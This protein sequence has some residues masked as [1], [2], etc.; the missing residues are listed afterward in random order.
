MLPRVARC[1]RAA[2]PPRPR[3]GPRRADGERPAAAAVVREGFVVGVLN[4]KALVFFIAVFPHFVDRTS[5]SVTLQ[6]LILGAIFATT[7]VLLRQRV[8][9]R[10]RA[11]PRERLDAPGCSSRCVRRAAA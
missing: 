8:G 7:R 6:L 9:A 4:P 3:R 11:R 2:P 10:P 1:D 5:G